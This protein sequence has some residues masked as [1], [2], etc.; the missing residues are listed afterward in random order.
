MDL[1]GNPELAREPATAAVIAFS[2]WDAKGCSKLADKGDLEGITRK[3]NGP[4][5]EG[6]T[7]RRAATLKALDI[8]VG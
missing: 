1:E 8:W 3:I 2:F 4:K 6:L 5:M 7:E